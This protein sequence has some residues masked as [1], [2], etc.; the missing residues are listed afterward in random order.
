MLQ[1]LTDNSMSW[2]RTCYVTVL[3]LLTDNAVSCY[4]TWLIIPCHDSEPAMS[5]CWTCWLTMLFH[6]A[7]PDWLCHVMIQSLL[8]HS[9]QPADWQCCFMLQ[10]LTDCAMSWYRACY[11]TALSPLTDNAVSCC[12]TYLT[13]PCHDTEPATSQRSARWLTML[14]HVAEPAEQQDV[15]DAA[16]SVPVQADQTAAR[17]WPAAVEW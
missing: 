15:W 11:I 2:F 8:C 13:V 14:F 5:P 1:N 16:P 9:A 10:N 6:V 17:M 7:E 12:W 3:N 4:R